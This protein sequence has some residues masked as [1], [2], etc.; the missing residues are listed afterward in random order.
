M[1]RRLPWLALACVLAACGG[2][3]PEFV[4]S[5]RDLPE[6]TTAL[7]MYGSRP[8][9]TRLYYMEAASHVDRSVRLQARFDGSAPEGMSVRMRQADLL[10]RGSAKPILQVRLPATVG[11]IKGTIVIESDQ[12]PGWRRRYEFAGTVEDR[13]LEGKYLAVRP[14]GM[15]LGDL[16][17]GEQRDFVFS[18]A[19]TGTEAVTI[20]RVKARDEVHIR[21][22]RAAAGILVPGGTQQVTGVFSAPKA[23]GPFQTMIDVRTNA[24][25]FRERVTIALRCRVVPDYAPHPAKLGPA[26]YYPVQER[27]FP[28]TLRGREGTEPFT[29]GKITGHERYL[30]V[31]ETGSEEAAHEQTVVF[32]LKRDAP[33]DA[34]AEQEFGIRLRLEPFG[35]EV[36]WPVRMTLNPPIYAL[37]PRVHFG[38]VPQGLRRQIEILLAVVAG[39]RFT[40][41]SAKAQRGLFKV[42]IKHAP[43][44]SWR[45][46]VTIPKRSARGLLQDRIVIETDDPDVPRIVVE[47]KADVR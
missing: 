47:V 14:P 43:G 32:K 23:A 3:A 37:P 25:N 15:D 13:P 21:L 4:L 17:Q 28:V 24:D 34:T 39:R 9:T 26:S 36:V 20:H 1:R 10:P 30:S 11:K 45:I 8:A 18:L 16:R 44:L 27:E 31:Q 2:D 38:R 12:L 5:F 7:D 42:E 22:S 33:T 35:A 6:E 46:I 29:V 19:S 41:K 40:V